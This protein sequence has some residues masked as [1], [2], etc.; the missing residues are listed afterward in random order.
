MNIRQA[1]ES[2][3]A[4]RIEPAAW[5]NLW[6]ATITFAVSSSLSIWFA[7]W[8]DKQYEGMA[9]IL[10]L[11]AILYVFP[12]AYYWNMFFQKPQPV[13][14]ENEAR[15]YHSQKLD[16]GL[17]EI[18][19]LMMQKIRVRMHI[20]ARI[21]DIMEERGFKNQIAF[22]EKLGKNHSEVSKFL[23]G[24]H[25][26]TVDTL[27]EISNALNVEISYLLEPINKNAKRNN[28]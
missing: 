25:N 13:K 23:S 27:V 19:P 28:N 2:M 14:K 18:T 21:A 26:F 12:T 4:S 15:E 16:D 5:D 11:V 22:A 1:I 6:F 7:L 3:K 17:A 8:C 10:M 9:A 24:T 20:S